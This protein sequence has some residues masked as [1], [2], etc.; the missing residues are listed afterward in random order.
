MS[1]STASLRRLTAVSAEA[2]N[3]AVEATSTISRGPHDAIH[4]VD[5][6][7]GA[8]MNRSGAEG[9]AKVPAQRPY[10]ISTSSSQPGRF[11]TSLGLLPSGGPMMPSRCM[12]S[13][14]RAARP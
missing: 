5:R 6:L 11:S 2:S 8:D 4:A 1:L 7:M 3:G 13:R 12:Q 14:I 10:R 9:L